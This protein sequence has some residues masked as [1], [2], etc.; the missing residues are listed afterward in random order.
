MEKAAAVILAAGEGKRM[1]TNKSKVLHEVLFKP[2]IDWVTDSVKEAAIDNICVVL[3]HNADQVSEHLN[4]RGL[5]YTYVRQEEQLGT[6]HA[7][8][9]AREY[10]V[11][12]KPEDVLILNGDVP[13]INSSII[14]STYLEHK[15]K[16]ND[17]TVLTSIAD[18][19]YGYG[20]IVRDGSGNVTGIIEEKD[21][22][23]DE[24]KIKEINA[25]AYWFKTDVLL[26]ALSHLNSGNV[27]H[28]YYLTDTVKIICGMGLR[29]GTCVIDMKYTAGANSRKQLLELNDIARQFVF[30][31]LF[32][33]G[34]T[35]TDLSGV[36]ISP[37]AE[38]GCDTVILPG[39]IIKGKTKIGTGC[40]I[41][42]NSLIDSCVLGNNVVFNASQARDSKI[43]DN[44]TVGPFS[45]LRPNSVLAENVHIGDFVE[46]KNSNI[47]RG[48]KVAHLT[49]VGDSDVGSGVNFGCGVVTVNY[50]GVKKSRTTIGDNA[51]IGCNTNLIAPVKVGNGAYTAAGSTITKDI[52]DGALSVAR[53]R[54]QNI[55]GWAEKKLKDRKK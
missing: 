19:P 31:K 39:T 43:G 36:S 29:A 8:M 24:R 11:K 15:S 20:R 46:V 52:P 1:K 14:K 10:L 6:G 5:K 41:G 18:N 38:I 3:G 42:P 54:Q 40:E 27:Q 4:G 9:Q 26:E 32:D 35:I 45:N 30:D 13:F 16:N 44:V 47:G 51:F 37:D 50:D 22:T 2:M 33:A 34:V 25:G 48:T 28:E 7:V 53:S 21:A 12:T 49:Y 17:V 55:D 23:D